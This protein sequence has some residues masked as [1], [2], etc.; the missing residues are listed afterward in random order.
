MRDNYQDRAVRQMPRYTAIEG[1]FIP[2]PANKGDWAVGLICTLIA[3]LIFIGVL[4]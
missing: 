4:A 3:V 2:T 1:P